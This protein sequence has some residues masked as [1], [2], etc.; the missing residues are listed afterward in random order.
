V[1]VR[2][3]QI[4]GPMSREKFRDRYFD[5][6][7]DPA[8]RAEWKAIERIEAIAWDGYS[9]NRKSPFNHRAGEGYAD[10]DYEPSDEWRDTRKGDRG[11]RPTSPGF[12]EPITRARRVG[13]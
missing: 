6:Y 10:P 11:G 13:R 7:K 12:C 8:Y 9:K 4:A 2:K 1:K 3:G 5:A